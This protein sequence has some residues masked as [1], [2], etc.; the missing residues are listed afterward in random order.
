MITDRW[1]CPYSMLEKF[2]KLNVK[3]KVCFTTKNYP[4]FHWAKQIT[5]HSEG[6][7]YIITNIMNIWGK[8]LYEYAPEFNY[9][10]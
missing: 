8:R 9:I 2:D 1:C 3:N 7:V 4:E 5:K 10:D 6:C